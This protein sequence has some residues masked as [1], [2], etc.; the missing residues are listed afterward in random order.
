MV[1][2]GHNKFGY[3]IGTIE[4]QVI[5]IYIKQLCIFV[6]IFNSKSI[7]SAKW[8]IQTPSSPLGIGTMI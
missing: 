4:R 1:S 6:H 8:E 5:F 3:V 2:Q 7:E